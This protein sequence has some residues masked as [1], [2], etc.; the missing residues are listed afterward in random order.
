MLRF[1][2]PE[3]LY[4]LWLVILFLGAE[5]LLRKLSLKK[6]K[7]TFGN[8]MHRYLSA[9]V[10]TWQRNLRLIMECLALCCFII[11]L[12]RPQL[13][14]RLDEIKSQGVE[15]M[16]LFDVSSSMMAED[17]KPNRLEQAKF[18]MSKLVDQLAGSKFGLIAFAG[19]AALLSPLTNDGSAIK[20]YLE[21]L[22]PDSVSTQGTEFASALKEAKDA[23]DRGGTQ[24]TESIRATRVLILASDGEDQE[25]GALAGADTLFKEGYRVFTLAYGTEKGGAIPLRDPNGYL[26]G[27]KKDKSG[28]IIMSRSSGKVLQE[29][30]Q[31]GKG[32]FYHSYF[33][34][35][36]IENLVKD[37]DKLEK[38]QFSSQMTQQYDEKYQFPLSLGFVIYLL[39]MLFNER[40]KPFRLWRG[41]S[42][43]PPA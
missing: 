10:S 33:G 21:S 24:V 27:Y 15:I 30:A 31:A 19:S 38:A 40:R 22:T 6:M 36:H 39:S 37:I 9:S 35:N 13:G 20:M 7:A 42:E 5:V 26:S 1:E 25:P 2:S 34:G 3:I 8:K 14:Q 43:V 28:N 11:A 4:W 17:V 12:A 29:L 41:R 16:I 23:F 18:D 32:S